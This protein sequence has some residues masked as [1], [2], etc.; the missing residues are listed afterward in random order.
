MADR[1]SEGTGNGAESSA[2]EFANHAVRMSW[3]LADAKERRATVAAELRLAFAEHIETRPTE[4]IRFE[5]V[6]ADALAQAFLKHPTVIKPIAA[7][8]NIAGRAIE[9]DLGFAVNTY[10][11]KLTSSQASQLAGYIKPFLPPGI[12]LPAIEAVD[13]WFFIDK[14]IRS[15]QGRWESLITDSLSRR[16][17]RDFKKR[18]FTIIDSESGELLSFELD[19]ALPPRGEP[20]EVGIDVKRIGS[21]RDIH[22]RVDEIVNKAAKFKQQYPHGKFGAV[23]YYPFDAATQSNVT[24]RMRSSDI[25]GVVFPAGDSPDAVVNAVLLLIPQLGLT[26]VD[27]TEPPSLFDQIS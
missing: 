4:W 7:I 23:V 24:N 17:G 20:I 11:P 2:E 18:K 27:D 19:A 6:T 1:S 21:P 15:Y 12:A 14:E 10:R 13:D 16:T 3:V 9:R 25:D 22:K 26:V 8:C 5:T